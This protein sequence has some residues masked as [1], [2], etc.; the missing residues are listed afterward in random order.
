[1]CPVKFV[2]QLTWLTN[3]QGF[4]YGMIFF[5]SPLPYFFGSISFFPS[6]PLLC[7]VIARSSPLAPPTLVF[8]ADH[9]TLC[10]RASQHC[11]PTVVSRPRRLPNATPRCSPSVRELLQEMKKEKQI[12][13]RN[14]SK[15]T[16]YKY[17]KLFIFL[18][19]VKYL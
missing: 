16:Y 13:K 14:K 3:L 4:C 5:P 7:R 1:V 12:E 15:K 10:P 9:R 17:A 19:L 2:S 6:S 8:D 18:H 11:A